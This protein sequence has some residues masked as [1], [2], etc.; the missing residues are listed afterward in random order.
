[1]LRAWALLALLLPGMAAAQAGSIAVKVTNRAT[2]QPISGVQVFVEGRSLGGVTNAQGVFLIANVPAG[3]HSVT[4]RFLGF[5]DATQRN[6][7]VQPGQSVSA[8]FELAET[9]LSLEAIRASATLDPVAG[10]KSPFSVGRVA[11]ENLAPV[12]AMS[13]AITAIQG[14]IAGVTVVNSSGMPGMD[15]SRVST[16]IVLRTPASI[17][18]SV[19]PLFV[20]DG[21]VMASEIAN[22]M[23]DID[24][25]DIES[26]E[27]IKGAAAASLYGS[28]ANAGVIS[29]T[30]NRGRGLALDQTRIRFRTEIGRSEVSTFDYLPPTHPYRMTADGSSFADAAGNPVNYS[31][32][33]RGTDSDRVMDNPWP[34]QT[35]DNV[36][37]LMRPG[38]FNATNAELSYN[39]ATS[40]MLVS[41]N[42]LIQRGTL[43][44]NDGFERLNFRVNLDHRLRDNF[45]LSVSAT[46][47]RSDQDLLAN[48][49]SPNSSGL[50]FNIITYPPIIDLAK[51]D[52]N[53]NYIQVPDSSVLLNNPLWLE[54]SRD[55]FDRRA[56]TL[57]SG[58]VRFNPMSWL[59]IVGSLSYDRSD[60]TRNFY[61]AKGLLTSATATD[62]DPSDGE[63]EFLNEDGD[64]INGSLSVTGTRTLGQLT[65]RVTGRALFER[66][67]NQEVTATGEDFWVTVPDL[68][69]AAS[70]DVSSSLTEVRSSGYSVSTGFDYAGKYIFDALIR[71]DGSSLFGPDQRWHTYGRVAAAYRMAQES[72]WPFAFVTEFKPRYAIGTAGGRPS[73]TRQYE[74]WTVN[75]NTGAVTKG[76]LGNRQLK[77][78]F[79][80]EQE[81]GIDMIFRNKYQL[82]LTYARQKTTDNIIQMTTP[83][84][85][86]YLDQWQNEGTIEGNTLEATLQASIVNQ[87]NFNWNMTFVWDRSRSSI[88]EWNRACIGDSNSLG[89][90][91][92][93]RSRGQMLGYAFLHSLDELPAGMQSRRDEFQVNDEGYVVY[94]GP[95]NSYTEG[96]AKDLWGTV[97]NFASYPVPVQW[98]HPIVRQNDRGFLDSKVPIGNSAP[99]FQVG[100]LNNVNWRG[101]SLHLQFH[102]SVGGDTYNNTRRLL[103][104]NLRHSDLDQTGKPRDLQ[105]PIDYYSAGIASG[106]WFVNEAFVESSTYLKL[107]EVSLQYRFN[108]DQL[109]S[110]GIGRYASTL[111]FGINGRNIFTLDKYRGFDPEVGGAFFK[112]DQW[113]YPPGRTWTFTSE[114]TF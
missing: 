86:G 89:E 12:P 9:V 40:N 94:V 106:T 112:V 58:D 16:G 82:E 28:R 110:I 30:T 39:G 81:M 35:Y 93:G 59:S 51:K 52:E 96:F 65:A 36:K 1:M 29:I 63:M 104:S 10:V 71:R 99:D 25:A 3:T 107:R 90:L 97:Y 76:T 100:W 8:I 103:Y 111:A 77:P 54:G 44:N 27:V 85:T 75:G 101:L 113:Y 108:R 32:S 67:K 61:E 15:V 83:G 11:T 92:A 18:G 88:T 17:S 50:F 70:P 33:G 47:T 22:T 105:K 24:A 6:I 91:C 49:N 21:V 37:A 84:L 7:V 62:G 57:L 2:G 31:S 55:N 26:V 64:A 23:V 41:M 43:V 4:A 73:F 48:S 78:E 114:I 80:V 34:G 72:W 20:V 74:T 46:H 66:E 19:T 98:G 79:T 95:G 45:S 53:G 5:A 38:L 42:R 13:D 56:R 14:K 60:R 68:N 69:F 109:R 102:A 87:R